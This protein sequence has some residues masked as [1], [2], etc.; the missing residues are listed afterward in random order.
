ML[1]TFELL[2]ISVFRRMTVV[3]KS[4]QVLFRVVSRVAAK[5]LVVNFQMRRCPADLASPA[6]PLQDAPMQF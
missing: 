1:A 5:L 3:A 2:L 6:V 4:D